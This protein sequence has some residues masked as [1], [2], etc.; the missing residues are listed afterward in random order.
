MRPTTPPRVTFWT[1][2]PSSRNAGGAPEGQADVGVCKA[3]AL[4]P[5]AGVDCALLGGGRRRLRAVEAV[6]LRVGARACA[7]LCGGLLDRALDNPD[8]FDLLGDAD[9]FDHEDAARATAA[10]VDAAASAASSSSSSSTGSSSSSS[11]GANATAHTSSSSSSSSSSGSSGSSSSS[12]AASS[13]SSV[14]AAARA[15]GASAGAGA[16]G[17]GA[18]ERDAMRVAGW[19]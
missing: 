7:R 5:P 19:A 1:C 18:E 17:S 12:S 15:A 2:P 3:R 16:G 4:G 13:S 10:A 14:S 6:A 8:V 11:A 9:V